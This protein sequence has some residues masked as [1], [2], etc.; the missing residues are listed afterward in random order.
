MTHKHDV[1]IIGAGLAGLRAAL[2]VGKVADVAVL[3]KLYPSRSHSGAAQGGIA[4]TLKNVD[5]DDCVEFHMFDTIKGSDYLGDQDAIEN[6]CNE[7][8]EV[9]YETEHMGVPYS[10]TAEG[11]IHQRKFGG[12]SLNHGKVAVRRSCYAA[13]YTGHVLL[14]TFFEQCI[15]NQVR[16]YNEFQAISLLVKDNVC[17]GF[18]A[19]DILNGGL[20]VFH[21]KAVMF[22]TGGYGRAFKITSN[23]HSS[24]GDGLALCTR[25]GLPIEDMEFVQFHPTGLY[26]QGILVSEGARGEGAYLL[27]GNNERFMERYAPTLMELAPRDMVARAIQ[28]ELLEGRGCGPQKDHVYLDIRHLGE[29]KIAAVIPQ[30]KGLCL[31]FA[32]ID[33]IK[34]P[35]PIQPTAHY[36]MGGIPV[37]VDGRVIYDAKNS[38]VEGLYAAGECACVSVH[39]ANRLGTNSLLDATANGRRTGKAICADVGKLKH[40]AL[41]DNPEKTAQDEMDKVLGGTG[42]EK[43]IRIRHD[44]RNSMEENCG[45]LRT[46]EKLTKQKQILKDLHERFYNIKIDDKTK[47]FNSDL[48]EAIELG[49]MLEFSEVIVEGAL[50]RTESRGG[51]SRTDFPKRDDENWLKHTMAWRDGDGKITFDYKPVIIKNYQPMERKY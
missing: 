20:H 14:H 33:P 46:S 44:L 31:D 37:T 39:G 47:I 38:T 15:K 43:V 29:A 28:T 9:I 41:P 50:N 1:I 19:W 23:A 48:M 2:E 25:V 42:K 6:M 35:I 21:A 32:A 26:K 30:I 18:V 45:V 3:T 40:N 36:S 24:T 49:H 4:A 7:A 13:D 5:S 12:H 11:K 16:F 34:E 22:A 10:R 51:H 17:Q 8:P 27:N